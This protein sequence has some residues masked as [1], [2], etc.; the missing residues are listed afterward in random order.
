LFS[1]SIGNW[2]SEA[3]LIDSDLL[4]ELAKGNQ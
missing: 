4:V 3:E 2:T 1:V